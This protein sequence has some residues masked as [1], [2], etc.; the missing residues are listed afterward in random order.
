[1]VTVVEPVIRGKTPYMF[2]KRLID[3]IGSAILLVVLAPLL[4][5]VAVA[6]RLDSPGPAIYRQKRVGRFGK[7]FVMLKFRTMRVGTPNLSTEE[8]QRRLEAGLDADPYTRLGP[9]LRKSN[10]DE[11]PQLVNILK[12]EM[13]FIGPRPALP[14]QEDVVGLRERLGA[15]RIRPGITGLAQVMG[16]DDLDVDTK[17]NYDS[18][19][20]RK[21]SLP[22]DLKVFFLTFGA[23]LSARGNR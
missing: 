4:L 9:F 8:L 10:L 2:A 16:R 21:L 1:M 14:S 20:C 6:I 3:L 5:L 23:V 11:F 13:S 17:V 22:F 7:H 18:E 12:G 15:D 19:Y